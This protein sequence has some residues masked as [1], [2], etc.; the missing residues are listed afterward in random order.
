MKKHLLGLAIFSFI[1][2]AFA[3][4][5]AYFYAPKVLEIN[6]VKR[7][8]F[9]NDTRNRCEKNFTQ[10]NSSS[11]EITQ[12]NISNVFRK[13]S[14]KESQIFFAMVKKDK[15]A[16]GTKILLH[17]FVGD[18]KTISYAATENYEIKRISTDER[19]TSA[20]INFDLNGW[21]KKFNRKNNF[22]VIPQI[23]T[24]DYNSDSIQ[25]KFDSNKAIPVLWSENVSSIMTVIGDVNKE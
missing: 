22:Y 14:A 16:V 5:F 3:I 17:F 25:P 23:V 8:V 11:I 19:I 7:P 1:F 2:A 12:P 15:L 9:E 18:G 24:E 6:E 10:N 21:Q 13:N 4:A 20:Y